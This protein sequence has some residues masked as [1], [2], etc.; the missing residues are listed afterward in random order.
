[1][2]MI[3]EL[4]SVTQDFICISSAKKLTTLEN[5]PHPEI[6]YPIEKQNYTHVLEIGLGMKPNTT[7]YL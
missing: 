4:K 1:M 2:N 7:L 3:Y 6:Y 5:L